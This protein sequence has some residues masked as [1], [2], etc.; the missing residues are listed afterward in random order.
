MDV[1]YLELRSFCPFC[2]P[3]QLAGSNQK[4]SS[5]ITLESESNEE[6]EGTESPGVCRTPPDQQHELDYTQPPISRFIEPGTPLGA[7]VEQPTFSFD[8]DLESGVWIAA[9]PY[10]Q[11]G[12]ALPKDQP[13]WFPLSFPQSFV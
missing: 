3:I 10:L 9:D 13:D 12:S 4:L 8:F 5:V 11:P 2:E 7:T 1:L 6:R